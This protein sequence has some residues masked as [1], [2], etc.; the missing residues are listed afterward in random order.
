[1]VTKDYTKYCQIVEACRERVAIL[2]NW[3]T[4]ATIPSPNYI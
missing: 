2:F 4:S 3:R 1:M